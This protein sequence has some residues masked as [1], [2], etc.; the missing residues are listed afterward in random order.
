MSEK[1]DKVYPGGGGLARRILSELKEH[2]PFTLV[3]AVTGVLIMVLMVRLKVPESVSGHLFSTFHPLHVLLSA[4]VTAA[5]YRRHSKGRIWAVVLVGY[6]GSVGI[7]TLSDC[8]IPYLGEW[9]MGLPNRGL[10][11]GFIEHWYLV[12]PLA[13]AGIVIAMVWPRTK[14]P[15]FGHVLLSTWASLFH[16]MMALGQEFTPVMMGLTAVFLFLAVW[17]PCCASDIIFP[18]VFA[19]GAD[20]VQVRQT[21]K[22]PDVQK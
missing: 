9:L 17:L 22:R 7:A 5:M 21:V 15:H 8:L 20:G 13:I 12:N 3:G 16:M 18:L 6:V 14:F 4:L 11:L 10:H 2:A 19:R 1:T